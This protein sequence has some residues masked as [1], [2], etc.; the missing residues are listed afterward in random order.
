MR[1]WTT[2]RGRRRGSFSVRQSGILFL[3][4]RLSRLEGV[5]GEMRAREIYIYIY[6]YREREKK[7]VGERLDNNTLAVQRQ[8]S[9]ETGRNA[10]PSRPTIAAGGIPPNATNDVSDGTHGAEAMEYNTRAMQRQLPGET[11][12]SAPP[13]LPIIDYAGGIFP[14]ARESAPGGTREQG[15]LLDRQEPSPTR[16]SETTR[17]V[18]RDAHRR[19]YGIAVV[20]SPEEKPSG[21]YGP[22][23]SVEEKRTP[24]MMEGCPEPRTATGR[25]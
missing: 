22:D 17:G 24:E 6:N 1:G 25:R 9:G 5:H 18:V 14:R 23:N 3:A 19:N 2:T 7:V 13:T 8:L 11:E 21:E 12:L 4:G 15:R 20:L 16:I 10:L